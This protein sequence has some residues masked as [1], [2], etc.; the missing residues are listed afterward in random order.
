[1]SPE[2]VLKLYGV[3]LTG[4][5]ATGKSTVANLLRQRSITVI[6]ADQLARLVTAPGTPGLKKIAEHFGEQVLT[7]EGHLNRQ[8]LSALVFRDAKARRDLEAITHP[9]IRAALFS[10][11]ERLDLINHPQLFFYEA[12]L[13][14]ET[15]AAPNFRAVWATYCQPNLQVQ[16]LIQRNNLDATRAAE[17]VASQMDPRTKADMADAVIDTSGDLASVTRQLDQLLKTVA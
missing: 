14:F 13:I 17:I 15:N 1:M 2:Q 5:V 3:A 7:A 6:D 12:A 4:G 11:L 16:R 10:E 8:A 9:R